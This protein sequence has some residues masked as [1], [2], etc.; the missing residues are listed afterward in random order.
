MISRNEYF[1]FGTQ[2]ELEDLCH[3]LGVFLLQL[4]ETT[5]GRIQFYQSTTFPAD[6]HTRTITRALLT[7]MEDMF[8]RI[9]TSTLMK[10]VLG[11]QH[12]MISSSASTGITG[13]GIF[14][15]NTQ[16]LGRGGTAGL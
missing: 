3:A 4:L 13:Q 1:I 11:S 9:P 5:V 12:D 16:L 14:N 7:S 2:D 6:R 15:T 10:H 8:L